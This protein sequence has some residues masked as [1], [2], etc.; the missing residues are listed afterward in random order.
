MRVLAG[1]A[2]WS[3]ISEQRSITHSYPGEEQNLIPNVKFASTY[4]FCRELRTQ[5]MKSIR[6]P[7]LICA[8]PIYPPLG[9]WTPL[10]HGGFSLSISLVS[11]YCLRHETIE[12]VVL[13]PLVWVQAMRISLKLQKFTRISWAIEISYRNYKWLSFFMFLCS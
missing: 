9:C 1:W 10:H 7:H 4:I 13:S 8:L 11:S 2:P 12:N 3:S 5:I 6:V